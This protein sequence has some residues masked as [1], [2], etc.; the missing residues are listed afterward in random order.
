MATQSLAAVRELAE[1]ANRLEN[2]A[3]LERIE[4]KH[5]AEKFIGMG[6]AVAFAS[7]AGYLDGRLDITKMDDIEGDGLKVIG[8]PVTPLAGGA[9]LVAGLM[10]GG[11]VG[12]VVAY[13]GLGTLCGWGYQRGSIAGVKAALASASKSE[14]EAA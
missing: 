12:G 8:M 7:L 4:E 9:L 10:T 6:T 1:R 14:E 2:R 13:A 11:R 5:N 3:K